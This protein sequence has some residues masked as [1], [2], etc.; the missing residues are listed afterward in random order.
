MDKK[1]WLATATMIGTIVGVG[2][3]GL[4]YTVGR[5]GF[6]TVVLYLAGLSLFTMVIHLSY[7]EIVLRTKEDYRLV[8]YAE[9][10]F[11]NWAK[12]LI[13]ASFLLGLYGGQIA[14][15]IVGGTFLKVIFDA[16]SLPMPQIFWFMAFALAGVFIVL[17]GLGVV[18]RAEFFMS[19][20]LIF[21]IFSVFF[22]SFKH[23]DIDNYTIINVKNGFMPYGVVLFSLA[24]SIAVPEVVRLLRGRNGKIKSALMIAS[25][26]PA[27][28]YL[29]FIVATTGMLGA[30]V[31]DQPIADLLPILGAKI[32]LI[33]S[34][35]GF[36]SC[37][38]SYIIIGEELKKM[39]QLDWD[40][41]KFFSWALA[42][43]IPIGLFLVLDLR[44]YI[45]IIGLLGAIFGGINGIMI[46][47]LLHKSKLKGDRTPEYYLNVPHLLSAIM[48]FL[49]ILGAIAEIMYLKM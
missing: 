28:L 44:D 43:F 39:Y 31:T 47:L 27:V 15:I 46:L 45:P 9:K 26:V 41:N 2:M 6:L 36:L 18:A 35:F 25:L 14:Y 29:I 12:K 7:G 49:M 40:I 11:G 37:F 3:F 13:T 17:F 30:G 8:G 1:F 22:L 48:I 20:L 32:V 38:T 19:G 33:G 42:M 21:V 16:I 10:Y 5:A 23:I 24:G 34:I 4:P